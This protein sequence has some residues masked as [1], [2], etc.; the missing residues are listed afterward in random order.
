VERAGQGYLDVALAQAQR[1]RDAE[2]T[3]DPLEVKRIAP[4]VIRRNIVAHDVV[5]AMLDRHTRR[6]STA[7]T[8]LAARAGLLE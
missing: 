7:L 1:K 8:D 3:L 6:R 5:R 4:E 2:A